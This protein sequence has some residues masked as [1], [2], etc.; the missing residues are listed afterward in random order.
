M[1]SEL[2]RR[3]RALIVVLLWLTALPALAAPQVALVTMEPGET[4]W[5]RF[6]HNALL[7]DIGDGSEPLLYNYGMFDFDEPGFLIKF[8]RGE[9]RY[10][11]AVDGY[12]ES[13][14]YYDS[15]GRGVTVQW[16]NLAPE[17]TTALIAFLRWNARPENAYYRYDYFLDNCS[18]RVRDAL[19]LA[20]GG[21][22]KPQLIGRARGLSYRFEALRLG[23]QPL[24]MGL[25][26]SVGLGPFAERQLSRW[27]EA[28]VPMRLREAAR[29]AKTADGAPLVLAEQTLLPH[30]L[31]ETAIEPPRWWPRFLLVG[32]LGAWLVRWSAKRRPRLGG[33]LAGAIWLGIGSVGLVLL[34][35][36]TLT[37][38]TAAWA[39]ENLLL[40][41]PLALLLVPLALARMRG[42][43]LPRWAQ[44]LLLAVTVLAAMAVFLKFLP[45]RVQSNLDWIV[46]MLPLHLALYFSFRRQ[47]DSGQKADAG[48]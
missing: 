39:N 34:A 35:L 1:R 17:Q 27:D 47:P 18:T 22:L 15:I 45:L 28:F 43:P 26:M 2:A 9:M 40:F 29:E 8:M 42:L 32:L 19:D 46:L 4:Y 13:L 41:N 48:V 38:H 6:G 20:L 7:V 11:L 24:W 21:A 36:W 23:Q 10:R 44:S 16:L 30:R 12:G 33:V 25:G 37:T 3:M 31:A 5:E 14:G